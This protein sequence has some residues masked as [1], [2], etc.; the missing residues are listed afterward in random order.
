MGKTRNR[1]ASG[2][3]AAATNLQKSPD[4]YRENGSLGG[5]IVEAGKRAFAAIP[6]L[7]KRAARQRHAIPKEAWEERKEYILRT[8][9]TNIFL[10]SFNI[11]AS[12]RVAKQNHWFDKKI[13]TKIT[14]YA[15]S[16]DKFEGG[17]ILIDRDRA[18]ELER[19]AQLGE[20]EAKEIR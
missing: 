4:Y 10:G 9:E 18:A 12:A 1:V 7:A 17:F 16:T 11:R 3:K 20:V 6:G 15:Y 13:K 14:R 19:L 8:V 2:K 5:R